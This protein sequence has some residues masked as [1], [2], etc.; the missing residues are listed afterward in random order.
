MEFLKQNSNFGMAEGQITII[1]QE[2]VPALI[3]NDGRFALE[4]DYPYEVRP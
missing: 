2:K 3:D 4:E 1:K